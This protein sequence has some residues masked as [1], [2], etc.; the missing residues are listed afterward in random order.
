MPLGL[1]SRRLPLCRKVSNPA[2]TARDNHRMHE[3]V[4]DFWLEKQI[5]RGSMPAGGKTSCAGRP[6]GSRALTLLAPRSLRPSA[7]E[8]AAGELAWDQPDPGG[9]TLSVFE[10][11]SLE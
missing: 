11:G 3:C 4:L 9:K 5:T 7:M 8:I 1:F 6:K 10:L 2:R